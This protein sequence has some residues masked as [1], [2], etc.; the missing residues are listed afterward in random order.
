MNRGRKCADFRLIFGGSRLVRQPRACTG[1]FGLLATKPLEQGVKSLGGRR[2]I[3]FIA[4]PFRAFVRT[5][6]FLGKAV[7]KVPSYAHSLMRD[8]P[9]LGLFSCSFSGEMYRSKCAVEKGSFPLPC[10]I[11]IP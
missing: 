2:T 5:Q 11:I 8:V 10:I 6:A 9:R 3:I 1:A 4:I 7:A